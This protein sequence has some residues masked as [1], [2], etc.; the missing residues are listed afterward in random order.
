MSDLIERLNSVWPCEIPAITQTERHAVIELQALKKEAACEILRLRGMLRECE[1]II[2]T[3]AE[4]EHVLDGFKKQR[5]P[6]DSL[7][8]RVR[9]ACKC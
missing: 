1:L 3:T 2:T 6:L 5:R 4:A 9:E 8:E 7:A